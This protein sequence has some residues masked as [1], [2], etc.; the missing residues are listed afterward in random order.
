MRD[1]GACGKD[2]EFCA[3]LSAEFY[4]R[5]FAGAILK[6]GLRAP[7]IGERWQRFERLGARK[8]VS[9]VFP[10]SDSEKCYLDLIDM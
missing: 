8:S 7:S 9:H 6:I 2:L 3:A 4:L 10:R 5:R 1:L